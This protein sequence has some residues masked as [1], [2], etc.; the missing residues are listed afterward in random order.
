MVEALLTASSPF[1]QGTLSVVRLTT[2]TLASQVA[3]LAAVVAKTTSTTRFAVWARRGHARIG[4][5]LRRSRGTL[6]FCKEGASGS[7]RV[8]GG[9]ISPGTAK[10]QRQA[11]RG[12]FAGLAEAPAQGEGPRD[13][14][15]RRSSPRPAPRTR[16]RSV[17][18][19]ARDARQ[20]SRVGPARA[21]VALGKGRFDQL[22]F[23]SLNVPRAAGERSRGPATAFALPRWPSDIHERFTTV[24]DLF[25][26]SSFAQTGSTSFGGRGRWADGGLRVATSAR[27]RRSWGRVPVGGLV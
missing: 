15:G 8:G 6:P 13:R 11:P 5:A 7:C 16:G 24:G 4:G 27:R 1:H 23:D 26:T 17:S 19:S 2:G 3:F 21:D 14:S 25:P 18:W 10:A 12:S 20:G 22:G 9:T